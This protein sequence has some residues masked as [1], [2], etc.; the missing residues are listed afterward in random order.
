MFYF[1]SD[2]F[3]QLLISAISAISNN[4][5]FPLAVWLWLPAHQLEHKHCKSKLAKHS[6][7]FPAG[8][9]R[10]PIFAWWCDVDKVLPVTSRPAGWVGDSIF[11]AR[12]QYRQYNPPHH[13]YFTSAATI[14]LLKP[15]FWC[16]QNYN[17]H[18]F[19]LDLFPFFC[20]LGKKL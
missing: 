13:A 19:P 5:Q 17:L 3:V 20:N 12:V 9:S 6:P 8:C 11:L 7:C 2:I 1:V 16:S 10:D 4:D 15:T 18:S 14:L